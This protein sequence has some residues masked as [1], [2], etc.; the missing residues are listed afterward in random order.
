MSLEMISETADAIAPYMRLQIDAYDEK[1]IFWE[2]YKSDKSDATN[3]L[4]LS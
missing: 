1:R 3:G 2:N 4:N